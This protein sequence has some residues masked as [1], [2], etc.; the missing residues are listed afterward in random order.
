MNFKTRLSFRE[1]S[2][3]HL[4]NFYLHLETALRN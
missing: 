4:G 1:V 2:I 3:K